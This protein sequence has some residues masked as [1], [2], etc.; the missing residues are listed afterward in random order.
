MKKAK[1]RRERMP[2]IPVALDDIPLAM[3]ALS[4]AYKI[5]KRAAS[6]GFD[7]PDIHGVI[8]KVAEEVEEVKVELND[9][10]QP[11]ER[12]ADEIGDLYFAL[13]NLVRHLG[14]KPEQVLTAAN[15]KF[16][17][18]FRLVEQLAEEDL[19]DLN[20]DKLEQI[21][22]NRQSPTQ[23]PDAIAKHNKQIAYYIVT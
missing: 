15:K 5:Q 7:W 3:P 8:D 20:I 13:T 1:E 18:R 16:E 22:A 11:I 6:V 4:R 17:S 23:N 21:M 2:P 12:I 10:E 19:R 14:L 9:P